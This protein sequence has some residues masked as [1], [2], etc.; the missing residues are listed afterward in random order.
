M[1]DFNCNTVKILYT[2]SS[3]LQSLQRMR[4]SQTSRFS[5]QVGMLVSMATSR[6]SITFHFFSLTPV[7]LDTHTLSI[8]NKCS[9]QSYCYTNATLFFYFFKPIFFLTHGTVITHVSFSYTNKR[10]SLDTTNWLYLLSVAFTRS[11]DDDVLLAK[12]MMSK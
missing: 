2:G 1:R 3:K 8:K 11:D 12:A 7:S 6:R 4:H 9:L 5:S 10:Q